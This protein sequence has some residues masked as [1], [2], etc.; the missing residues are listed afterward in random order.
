MFSKLRFVCEHI[1]RLHAQAHTT[2]NI[3]IYY[4]AMSNI[5]ECDYSCCKEE[6]AA[7]CIYKGRW[8]CSDAFAACVYSLSLCKK[9]GHSGMYHNPMLTIEAGPRQDPSRPFSRRVC[10]GTLCSTATT[11]RVSAMKHLS[12]MSSN[13]GAFEDNP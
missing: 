10:I 5:Y 4:C 3:Y 13:T 6:A 8:C 11:V 9:V 12:R 2:T 1:V 7:D